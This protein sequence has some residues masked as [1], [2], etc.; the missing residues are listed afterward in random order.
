MKQREPGRR[1]G[2]ARLIKAAGCNKR[3]KREEGGKDKKN[4]EGGNTAEKEQGTQ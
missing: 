3:M 1:E 2:A 4:V